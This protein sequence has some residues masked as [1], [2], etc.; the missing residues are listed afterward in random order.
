M[1]AANHPISLKAGLRTIFDVCGYNSAMLSRGAHSC[2]VYTWAF[3]KAWMLVA[4][5][6]EKAGELL[7][8][9]DGIACMHLTSEYQIGR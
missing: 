2:A 9:E 6:F 4:T 1:V 3:H 7:V 8:V 5:V